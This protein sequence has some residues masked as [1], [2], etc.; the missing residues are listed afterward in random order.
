[1]TDRGPFTHLDRPI[2]FL[3]G[4]GPR[5]ADAFSRLGIRTARD[6]LYHLPRRYTDASD[7]TPVAALN[8]GDEA[9]VV[10]KVRSKGVIPTRARLRVFQV[11]V[12]DD[13][14]IITAA[15]PGKP[16]LERRIREGDRLLLHGP[17]KFFH[18]R[19]IQPTEFA[20]IGRRGRG[21]A[22]S[23]PDGGGEVSGS[24]FVTYPATDELPQWL[25]RR[26]FDVN[27]DQ[28]LG[29]A[30]DDEYLAAPALE[31]RGLP[32]LSEA[33]ARLH[34]P[35]KS[36]DVEH[37]RR[38]LAF[39][40]L[41]ALQVVQARA[42][43]LATVD[44]PGI[45]HRRSNELIRVLH[46]S[47]PFDLTNAQ[48]R[49]LRE[50][51]ADM[52]SPRRMSRL[53]QGDVGSGKTVV[54]LFAMLIAVEGGRQA[55]IMAPTELL[56]EQHARTL[57]EFL[58]PLDISPTLLTGRLS[59]PDRREALAAIGSGAPV[60]VGTHA[61]IQEGVEFGGLGLVVVD[62]QHRF[63]VRQRLALA[64]GAGDGDGKPDLL[65]MSATPIPRS[66]ALTVYGDLDISTIDELPQ[67]RKPITTSLRRPKERDEIYRFVESELREGRQAYIVYPLVQQSGNIDLLAAEDE[68]GRLSREAFSNRRVGLLHG[69]LPSAEKDEVMR[70]FLSGR[71]DVLVATTVVEVGI[72][73]PNA[74]VMVVEH[75]ERFGLS[76]LH[77][78]RGR[79]GRG[80]NESHCIL[81]ADAGDEA[82]QRL[83]VLRDTQDGFT[84][85]RADL[86]LRGPGD[87]FGSQQ[88]G[89]MPALR[90]ADL[91]MD[92]D[93]LADARA[94]ATDLISGDPG[95]DIPEHLP[96]RRFIESR[97]GDREA[98]FAVG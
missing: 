65:V 12:E 44:T 57:S 18:G 54:A 36:A 47:L 73:V 96:L 68:Y 8:V 92:T 35:S 4:V 51:S 58:R 74:T 86:R 50:I 41:F 48:A 27:L 94:S 43:R 87:L 25:L 1:M 56:A 55:V 82:F 63:G 89:H 7:V 5:R 85:A 98:L 91:M 33:L 84:V 81:V 60:V 52:T 30:D 75:A 70:A 15:W 66:L 31:S 90:F 2:Q 93:L 49:A 10:G 46:Q 19:Q 69:K 77:Q 76:Q 17:V 88:H 32:R 13:S 83:R 14:G 64:G 22:P 40:E 39:D 78:M 20:I 53:V 42:R 71:I 11:T 16:F 34:R 67:G 29:W 26:I 24:V 28:L 9:T 61:L 23:D 62:E 80:G 6:L 45:A 37:G 97:Y 38:R 79:V 72:D 3:R 21:G 59:A 95:L